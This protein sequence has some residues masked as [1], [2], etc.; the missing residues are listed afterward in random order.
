MSNVSVNCFG[1]ILCLTDPVVVLF[2]NQP[3]HAA[4]RRFVIND[5][6]IVK[7]LS[8]AIPQEET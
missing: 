6:Q 2:Q 3:Q 1:T 4:H 7:F 8:H 5:Q